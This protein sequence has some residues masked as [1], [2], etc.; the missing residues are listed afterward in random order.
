MTPFLSVLAAA[1]TGNQLRLGLMIAAAAAIGLYL[2][3][4][5]RRP[6]ETR[7]DRLQKLYDTLTPELLDSVPDEELVD[8][9]IANLMAK[10][11][12]QV[13]DDYTTIPL[14]SHGQ[15]AVHSVWL[16]SRV[17]EAD[18]FV[19][20]WQ[21][22]SG[23]FAELAMDGLELIGAGECAAVLRAAFEEHQQ[24][25]AAENDDGRPYETLDVFT[26][27]EED[28]ANTDE[29][30]ENEEPED[31]GAE[32][33]VR[34]DDAAWADAAAKEQPLLLCRR[35]IRDNPSEFVDDP[36]TEESM[37]D[38]IDGSESET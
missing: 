20:Y 15:C 21:N 31:E 10:L 3:F 28:Y 26:D 13:P 8:A 38:E 14:Q 11:D 18:G 17:L 16:T 5:A 30:S 25:P 36:A 29:E 37:D 34:K 2:W 4:T 32:A 6:A 33:I 27:S 1:L 24:E 7:A 23:R 9:V 22:P 35:Y 12:S 19:G